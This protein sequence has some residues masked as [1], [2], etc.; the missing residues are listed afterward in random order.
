MSSRSKCED[1]GARRGEATYSK[2]STTAVYCYACKKLKSTNELSLILRKVKE[3][4]R[5]L[6]DIPL[7][8]EENLLCTEAKIYLNQFHF[9]EEQIKLYGIYWSAVE[10][11]LMF[12]YPAT[13]PVFAKG[14]VLHNHSFLQKWILYG[15][16]NRLL[17]WL[18]NSSEFDTLVI[19][20]DEI[21]A[22]RVNEFADVL[23]LGG[24]NV[25]PKDMNGNSLISAILLRYKKIILWL[26][27]DRA[28]HSA[29]VEYRRKWGLLR[30]IKLI[31]T[32]ED[33][34]CIEPERMQRLL[35][36]E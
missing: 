6:K 27:D 3:E 7:K 30:P 16:K 1:C 24:T 17:Y 9:T 23:A 8:D 33:P 36:G 12:P 14:K 35:N 19:V 34:K 4:V 2:G 22:C 26:D 10:R 5:T 25:D 29:I 13:N 20:E 28:G 15:E 31:H 11:R 18:T 32:K 21:S